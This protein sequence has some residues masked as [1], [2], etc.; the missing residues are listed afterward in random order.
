M[1]SVPS[2]FTNRGV[3]TSPEDFF[4]RK[5]EINEIL[6]R[7]RTMQS[8]AVVGE[9]RIG[10]S[11]LL[12][13]LY[14]TGVRRLDN[15]ARFRFLYLDLQ[16]AHYHTARGFLHTVLAPIGASVDGVK[17]EHPLNRNLVAFS[18][19]IEAWERAGQRIVLLLDE[20]ESAFKHPQEFT[21]DFF[22]HLRS[23]LSLRKLACVSTSQRPLQ[24]LCLEGKLTSPFYNVFTVTELKELTED[25]SM[26]LIAAYHE[27]LSF[28]ETELTF[29]FSYLD[30]HPLKLQIL[31]DWVI[32]NRERRLSDRDLIAGI[33]KDYAVFFPGRLKKLL[34]AKRVL[35]LD[36]I[37]KLLETA[38]G[39]RDAFWPSAKN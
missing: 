32:R 10:K 15:D 29:V 39:A 17:P 22:D 34:K 18:E 26:E 5:I 21:D 20:L 24:D 35:S 30:P 38:K 11:S 12:Y 36:N 7:L 14:Q 9:R 6:T 27:R 23:Q 19:A 16:D 4:G 33:G 31:C 3:I 37:K 28:T 2:P 1:N 25:E 8:T 13:H